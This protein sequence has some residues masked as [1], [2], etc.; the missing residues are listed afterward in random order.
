MEKEDRR[1]E[2][3]RAK[4]NLPKWPCSIACRV[5]QDIKRRFLFR[6]AN[7]ACHGIQAL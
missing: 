3:S 5:N 7:I 2:D 1:I 6:E 4:Q